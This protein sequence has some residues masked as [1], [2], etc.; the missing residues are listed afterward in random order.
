VAR[1]R[2]GSAAIESIEA[3]TQRMPPP[4]LYD[5]TELQ[6]PCQ[7]VSSASARRRPWMSRK[8]CTR[9]G[10][11]S[12]IRAPTAGISRKTWPP[13]CSRSSRR[14][15]APYRDRL[16]PGTGE[17]PLGRRFVDDAKVTDHHAII[18]TTVWR[19]KPIS[20]PMKAGSTSDLP[21]AAQRLARRSHLV[22]HHR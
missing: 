17:R 9:S 19:R 11:S 16:A 20:P 1:A 2:A 10:N 13:R 15:P 4:P 22:G 5:L 21:P 6:A 18:P 8:L 12:A 7:T 3:E 14:L